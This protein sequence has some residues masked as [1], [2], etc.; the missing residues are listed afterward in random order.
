[1]NSD[2]LLRK[3]QDSTGRNSWYL[4]SNEYQVFHH[5]TGPE[6]A[7]ARATRKAA[8]ASV[9]ADWGFHAG[10]SSSLLLLGSDHG[11]FNHA[12][13]EQ[14]MTKMI[15]EILREHSENLGL[16]QQLGVHLMRIS[17][18]ATVSVICKS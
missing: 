3:E 2:S 12:V 15:P 4:L 18:L 14:V 9:A 13:D 1:M 5:S 6:V 10:G 11:S 8:A 7:E 17:G 16:L